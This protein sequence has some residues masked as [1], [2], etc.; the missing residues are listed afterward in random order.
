MVSHI[1]K[2]CMPFLNRNRTVKLSA[3]TPIRELKLNNCLK[4]GHSIHE[5]FIPD[6]EKPRSKLC[7]AYV[8]GVTQGITMF[9]PCDFQVTRTPERLEYKFP[10]G[11]GK[12]FGTR[13]HNNMTHV[14]NNELYVTKVNFPIAVVCEESHEWILCSHTFNFSGMNILSGIDD[15]SLSH[16]LDLFNV[17]PQNT[18]YTVKAGTP[19][20]YIFLKSEKDIE[21]DFQW[22]IDKWKELEDQR[23]HL[24]FKA[25]ALRRHIL[26]KKQG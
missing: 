3:Y 19:L 22:S 9:S 25:D 15:Y 21:L 12:Y 8:K 23:V 17:T 4:I 2:H 24:H 10:D 13:P 18:D 16:G 26:R 7:Y 6:I 1:L 11:I 20:C 14:G 5:S